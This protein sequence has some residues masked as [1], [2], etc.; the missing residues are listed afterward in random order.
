[1]I[2]VTGGTGFLG[3]ELVERLAKIEKVRVLARDPSAVSFKSK[4]IEVVQG[5]VLHPA[6]LEKS[7]KGAK[8]VYHLAALVRYDL[9]QE[10]LDK[11]NV[12]G[13]ANVLQASV[14]NKVKRVVYASSV[15]AAGTGTTPYSISKERAEKVAKGFSKDLPVI[16]LRFAPIYGPGGRSGYIQD[17]AKMT[18]LGFL[19]RV[20]KDPYTHLLAKDSAIDSLVLAGKNGKSGVPYTLADEKPVKQSALYDVV[21]KV[22]GKPVVTFP[23]ALAYPLIWTAGLLFEAHGRVTGKKPLFSR[24]LINVITRNRSYDNA[25]AIKDLKF[26]PIDSIRGFGKE[27]KRMLKANK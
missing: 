8:Q 2:F 24:S 16:I 14:N 21:S 23:Y 5:D 22:S 19:I 9:S 3:R 11:V 20:S 18:K 25:P 13:T 15:A 26:K 27:I 4:N 17:L 10:E 7:M 6:E 12:R 1:M